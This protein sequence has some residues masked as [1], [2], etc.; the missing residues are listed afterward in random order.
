MRGLSSNIATFGMI[1]LLTGFAACALLL[2]GLM[3]VSLALMLGLLLIAAGYALPVQSMFVW[4]LVV[5]TTPEMWL[6]DLIGDHELVIAALKISGLALIA[7]SALRYRPRL[8]RFN[9]GF[10]FLAMFIGGFVHGLWPSLSLMSSLRSLIGS[11]APFASGFVEVP[12]QW[13]RA[14]V[15]A[16]IIGPVVTV[17]FGL[18]LAALRIRGFY[19]SELGAIRLNA[20]SNPAFL[21]GFALTAIYAGVVEFLRAGK[22]K[23]LGW[24]ALNLLVLVATG[25][26]APLFFAASVLV[27]VFGFIRSPYLPARRRA[28]VLAACGAGVAGIL[29]AASTLHFVRVIDLIDLGDAGD[30]SNRNLV[31]PVFEKAIAASPW[32]GWGVGAGKVIVPLHSALGTFL[33]TNAAHEEYLRISAEGGIPGA[34]L[35]VLMLGLWVMRGSADLPAAQRQTIRLVF[36]AFALHSTTDNTLIAT[37][38]LAFFTWARAVLT[39]GERSE[40]LNRNDNSG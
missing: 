12:P 15:R 19:Y 39:F 37:T 21:A 25:A 31:W 40:S 10:A 13:R 33:G 8:D 29:M 23:E 16:V 28:M 14:V 26:R 9:P 18:I 3:P 22:S 4:L 27:L 1:L 24:L 17:I 7:L 35:L 36:I 38:S 32:L 20:S 30:L 11:A 5:E 2:P 34:V 6:S